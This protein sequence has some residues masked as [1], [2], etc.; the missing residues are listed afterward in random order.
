[1]KKILAFILFITMLCS[2]GTVFAAEGAPGEARAVIGSNLTE[3]QILSVY[4]MFDICRG[5]VRS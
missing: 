1:M 5:S 4:D 2:F 3:E